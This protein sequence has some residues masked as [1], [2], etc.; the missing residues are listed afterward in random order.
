VIVNGRRI[1]LTVRFVGGGRWV[2]V[3]HAGAHELSRSPEGS[4]EEA[5]HYMN[6]YRRYGAWLKS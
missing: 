4:E 3:A 2:A 6:N 5:E 1:T